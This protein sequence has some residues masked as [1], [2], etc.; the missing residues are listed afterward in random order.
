MPS[1]AV[2]T[3][4]LLFPAPAFRLLPVGDGASRR[5]GPCPL[6]PRRSNGIGIATIE[7]INETLGPAESLRLGAIDEK[8]H[9][10]AVR[11]FVAK[12]Q[13][14]RLLARVP[15]PRRPVRQKTVVGVSP[16]RLIDRLQAILA[17][18]LHDGTPA[19]RQRFFEKAGQHALQRLMFEMIEKDVHLLGPL[20]TD[21]RTQQIREPLKRA[22][23]LSNP[24]R[25][26][27]SS[28]G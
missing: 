22:P 15:G 17:A 23:D 16:K 26:G 24:V 13:V 18:C 11:R 27:A 6:R 3:L 14:D 2:L 8:S 4:G 19:A 10:S 28:G 7:H 9:T 12:R 25:S 5:L 1:N 21:A 20:R